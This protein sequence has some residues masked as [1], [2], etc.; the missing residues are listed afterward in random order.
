MLQAF[1]MELG[2]HL[3]AE[4]SQEDSV[5]VQVAWQ[6][7]GRAGLCPCPQ[8]PS[9]VPGSILDDFS[10]DY[11]F[12]FSYI[13]VLVT[14]LTLNSNWSHNSTDNSLFSGPRMNPTYNFGVPSP[15][16]PGF[17]LYLSCLPAFPSPDTE[18]QSTLHIHPGLQ[19]ITSLLLQWS[20]W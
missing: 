15:S 8:A 2:S 16:Q 3:T 18:T 1:R 14:K 9:P 7:R 13:S 6:G 20:I 4:D 12:P 17:D 19:R 5:A 11:S 10:V